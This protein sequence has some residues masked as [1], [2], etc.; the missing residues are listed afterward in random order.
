MRRATTV[1]QP[2]RHDIQ[3]ALGAFPITAGVQQG[4]S[5]SAPLF[6]IAMDAIACDLRNS[7][8][9]T[10]MYT[11]EASKDVEEQTSQRRN[12]SLA[13]IDQMGGTVAVGRK[14]LKR[15]L[16]LSILAADCQQRE[17]I[18]H[19]SARANSK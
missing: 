12:R 9:W 4:S 15:Q 2:A 8:A 14:N 11:D 18:S 5:L 3:L 7:P 6:T 13:C 16:T 17:S 10:L 19:L 1:V